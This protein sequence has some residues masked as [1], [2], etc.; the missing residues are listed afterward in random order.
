MSYKTGGEKPTSVLGAD[1]SFLRLVSIGC[2]QLESDLT[3]RDVQWH[4]LTFISINFL[5]SKTSLRCKKAVSL[6]FF[7]AY[8]PEQSSPKGSEN[9]SSTSGWTSASA[10]CST[11]NT[12]SLLPPGHHFSSSGKNHSSSGRKRLFC[13]Q[14]SLVENHVGVA[15]ESGR[16]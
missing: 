14:K 3:L 7:A 9:W 13:H 16:D 10:S 6:L 8:Q 4:C 11:A 15:T 12:S 2:L 5:C 1:S